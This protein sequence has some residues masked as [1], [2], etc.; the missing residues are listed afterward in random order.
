MVGFNTSFLHLDSDFFC[1]D[2][3]LRQILVSQQRWPP[4]MQAYILTMYVT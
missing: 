3:L 4:E 1:V 2:L